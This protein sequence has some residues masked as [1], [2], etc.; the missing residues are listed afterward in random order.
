MVDDHHVLMYILIHMY[1]YIPIGS[2]YGICANIWG[3]LMVNVTIYSIH[4]SYGI[5][6]M[7]FP[8]A[9]IS[10]TS[11]CTS[12]MSRRRRS[13]VGTEFCLVSLTSA[14]SEL[15]WSRG[16]IEGLIPRSQ[17]GNIISGY[18]KNLVNG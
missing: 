17:H 13:I 15:T 16:F 4:G 8:K 10:L 6:N 11:G 2:M 12:Q 3:I 1:I 7:S 9:K 14:T 5:Y 18:F